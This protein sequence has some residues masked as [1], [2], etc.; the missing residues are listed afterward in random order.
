MRFKEDRL[1]EIYPERRWKRESGHKE[2]ILRDRTHTG[3]HGQTHVYGFSF[4]CDLLLREAPGSASVLETVTMLFPAS[5]SLA[6]P[7]SVGGLTLHFSNAQTTQ[8]WH[9]YSVQ[10][11]S[12]TLSWVWQW[13]FITRRTFTVWLVSPPSIDLSICH[14]FP[15][16]HVFHFLYQ[17][18]NSVPFCLPIPPTHTHTPPFTF[19]L[20]T[21]QVTLPVW[22]KTKHILVCVYLL[23]TLMNY[24]CV[25]CLWRHWVIVP[26][27]SWLTAVRS[28][29][30]HSGLT[31][32]SPHFA[33]PEHLSYSSLHTHK[34]GLIC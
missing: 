21:F 19:V 30:A 2:T 11:T 14:F 34:K 7:F 16:S 29:A 6:V 18:I 13:K 28:H 3:T 32:W 27:G 15:L 24:S 9:L 1:K 33:T 12:H 5:R 8:F 4:G 22:R 17:L 31:P 10:S 23:F 20:R 26:E 25:V